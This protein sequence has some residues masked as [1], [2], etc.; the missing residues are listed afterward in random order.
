M[1]KDTQLE[2]GGIW[3]LNLGRRSYVRNFYPK[4]LCRQVKAVTMPACSAWGP[5]ASGLELMFGTFLWN[6]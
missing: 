2:R 6:E 5:T 3:N 1:A 4:L